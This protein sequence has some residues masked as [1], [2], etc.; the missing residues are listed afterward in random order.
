[1][2]MT[3]RNAGLYILILLLGGIAPLSAKDK[4]GKKGKK[5]EARAL[6]TSM[7]SLGE[8]SPTAPYN[9]PKTN[10]IIALLADSLVQ[11]KESLGGATH[12]G[13]LALMATGEEKYTNVA[14]ST[15]KATL[16]KEPK[17][18]LLEN[19]PSSSWIW[20]YKAIL[21]AEYYL[22]TR[23]EEALPPLKSYAL[24]VAN[25]QDSAG[26]WGHT[27]ARTKSNR[28]PGYGQMN[29]PSL[30]CFLGLILARKCG[31]Q[32][33]GLDKAIERSRRYAKHHAWKG[34]FPYGFH[35]PA[36]GAY[37]NNGTS[38]SAAVAFSLLGDK[39]TTKYFSQASALGFDGLSSGH[40]SAFF[41]PLWTP[42][43]AAL[44]GPKV[45]AQF[46]Q[47]S[48]WFFD[49]HLANMEARAG[50]SKE[51]SGAGVN[52]L[53]RCVPRRALMITGREADAS[54][55][56]E[57]EKAVNEVIGR[58]KSVKKSM[59]VRELLAKFKS[60]FAQVRGEAAACLERKYK[61]PSGPKGRKKYEKNKAEFDQGRQR[62]KDGLLSILQSGNAL[63]DEKLTAISYF[64]RNEADE[65]IRAQLIR[66]LKDRSLPMAHRC[67]AVDSLSGERDLFGDFMALLLEDKPEDPYQYADISIGRVLVV[68]R[69]N[70]LKEHSDARKAGDVDEAALDKAWMNDVIK[71][72]VLYYRCVDKLLKH[73]RQIGRG[74]AIQM[75]RG[76]KF[77]NFHRIADALEHV[78]RDDDK[79]Y[80]SYHN[81]GFALGPGVRLY[82]KFQIQEGLAHLEKSVRARTGKWGFKLKEFEATIPKFG[83]NGVETFERLIADHKFM[84]KSYEKSEKLKTLL[85]RLKADRNPPELM[86]LEEAKA[87]SRKLSE[88]AK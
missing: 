43:G 18:E 15:I 29:Q 33:P 71:D 4:K 73:K 7:E 9:C 84:Q 53:M 63:H 31:I 35:G 46:H 21:L 14:F 32:D 70:Y 45:Y 56:I 36:T 12:A 26:L 42:L 28:A 16:P 47:R 44:S 88:E 57:D 23:D 11:S 13:T 30:S 69:M 41:N 39:N 65:P 77:E 67:A 75:L 76:V 55:W 48:L 50:S 80:H 8:Y 17:G 86:T 68:D 60:P 27:M 38:G 82:A 19:A 20:G 72:K 10:K 40:A 81:P 25:G 54:L 3:W 6:I 74:V 64:N 37:N 1:M 49:K 62:V 61:L 22:L 87:R 24:S 5:S 51:G 34:A 2:N 85:N 66:I 83:K 59:S 78:L 79:T 52:L 58:N